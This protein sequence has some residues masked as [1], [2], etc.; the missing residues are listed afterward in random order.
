MQEE[1]QKETAGGRELELPLYARAR[2]REVL[3]H[4]CQP[5]IVSRDFLRLP[6][7][8]LCSNKGI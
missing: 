8:Q 3:L 2:L 7:L 1:K 5:L 4:G 6:T